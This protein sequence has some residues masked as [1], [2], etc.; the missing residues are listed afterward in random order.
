MRKVNVFSIGTRDVRVCLFCN[1]LGAAFSEG[2]SAWG[3]VDRSRRLPRLES[4]A[5][6]SAFMK[7]GATPL[8]K[9]PGWTVAFRR[10]EEGRLAPIIE[11]SGAKVE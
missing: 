10:A 9:S 7:L 3:R 2:F 4:E 1:E 8:W 5:V 11:A 6:K